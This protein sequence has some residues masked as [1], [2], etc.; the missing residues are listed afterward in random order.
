VTVTPLFTIVI[1]GAIL[2]WRRMC[3]TMVE[4]H[5]LYT[6]TLFIKSSY[7]SHSPCA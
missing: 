5:R 7:V 3:I 6:Q 1:Y 2:E 4:T